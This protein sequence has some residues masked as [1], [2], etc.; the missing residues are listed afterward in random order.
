M[1]D[2]VAWVI[3]DRM[4]L[5]RRARTLTAEAQLSKWVLL[6]LPVGLFVLFNVMNRSYM[7]PFYNTLP[8]KLL[9]L[10]GGT[11]LLAGAWIMNRM[12]RINY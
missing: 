6:G 9:L 5:N 3:R 10:G 8:G 4:R 1:M 12:A 7:E 2:R 11:S